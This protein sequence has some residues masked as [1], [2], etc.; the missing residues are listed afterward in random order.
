M[1]LEVEA[2]GDAGKISAVRG[3]LNRRARQCGGA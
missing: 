1:L 3:V 2:S